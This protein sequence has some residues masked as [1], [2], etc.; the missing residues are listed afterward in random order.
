MIKFSTFFSAHNPRGHDRGDRV[1]FFVGF[2]DNVH[3]TTLAR[4]TREKCVLRMLFLKNKRGG[5][6][7]C[8][9]KLYYKKLE[10]YNKIHIEN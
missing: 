4:M 10:M 7:W 3:N 6:V 8:T 9:Q 5:D 1:C 2:F